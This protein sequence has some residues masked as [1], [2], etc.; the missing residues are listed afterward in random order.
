MKNINTDL[1]LGVIILTVSVLSLLIQGIPIIWIGGF[2]WGG[3]LIMRSYN[4][5]RRC[6]YNSGEIDKE[7]IN[8]AHCKNKLRVPKD[9]KKYV[10]I[11]CTHCYRSPFLNISGKFKR[12]WQRFKNYCIIGGAAL[13]ILAIFVLFNNSNQVV[14]PT[15][16]TNVIPAQLKEIKLISQPTNI[17]SFSTGEF[18][19]RDYKYLQG[20]GELLI[21]NGT[22]NSAVAKLVEVNT[23][24][25]VA[26]VYIEANSEYTL[27]S[28][29]NGVYKLVFNLGHDWDTISK[30]FTRNSSYSVFQD[31]FDYTTST[32]DNGYYYSVFNV[33]LNPVLGGTAETNNINQEEFS[34]Y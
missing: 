11:T 29:S 28:I 20:S 24:R 17:V 2:I 18:I 4:R 15:I 33:T 19:S 31:K 9:R 8:C 14:V 10:D 23:N 1:I 21:N 32:S 3:S 6:S 25:S 12:N 34:N 7:I 26:T 16:E 5:T 13:I 22:S 30:K 27:K